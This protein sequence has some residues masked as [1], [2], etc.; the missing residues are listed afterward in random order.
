[1]VR[2]QRRSA[3]II[4]D[5]PEAIP[6]RAVPITLDG[7]PRLARVTYGRGGAVVLAV[8]ARGAWNL[9]PVSARRVVRACNGGGPIRFRS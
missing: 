8:W 6:V 2:S 3:R 5:A 4:L 7:T 9:C 1:M